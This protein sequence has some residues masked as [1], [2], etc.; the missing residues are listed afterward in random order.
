[1][2]NLEKKYIE[3]QNR[4]NVDVS[5]HETNNIRMVNSEHIR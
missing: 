4:A 1:M 2:K 3:N 5:A